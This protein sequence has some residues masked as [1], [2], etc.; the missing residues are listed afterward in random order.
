MAKKNLKIPYTTSTNIFFS[1]ARG[2]PGAKIIGVTG[3]K[4]KS[5]TASL[6]YHILK[7]SGK[8]AELLGNIGVPMLS[9]IL[10]KIKKD[11]IF[12]LEL[13]SY[14]L[15]DIKFSP[16]IAVL[17]SLFP[18]HMDYH[19]NVK[20][21]YGAKKNII[22]YQESGDVFIFNPKNK[23]MSGWAKQTKA[24]AVPLVLEKF[25]EGVNSPLAGEHNKENIRAA[26]SAVKCFNIPDNKI[27][28]AIEKFKPLPH[29]LEF[30]GE[31]KGIKFY[32][33]AVST[34]PESTI[35]AI[36]SLKNID[37]IF[38]GGQ[39]RGYNFLQLERII[40]KYKIKNAALFPETG[41]KILKSL[42]G[43]NVLETESMREAVK[44]AY[45]NTGRGNICL[46]SCASP[47]YSLWKNFEEKGDQFK[48]AVQ[49]YGAK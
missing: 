18:E 29:R 23:I 46:L 24:K 10:G 36:K 49:E 17:T 6:I 2:I 13:S 4:G 7:K 8:K 11:A 48:K 32:D 3:T 30:I 40:K 26:V 28:R 15:D 21:Y 39:D 37:T 22:K 19:H 14:Q 9:A 1:Y 44:F 34:T 33:D 38:L 16:D 5:T 31:F 27:K 20:N 47:S 41:K 43:I 35:M 25:L 45:K 42:K 12:V